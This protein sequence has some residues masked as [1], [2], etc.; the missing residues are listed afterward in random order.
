MLD[1]VVVFLLQ[2]GMTI[3]DLA[4]RKGTWTHEATQNTPATRKKKW[5]VSGTQ[6]EGGRLRVDGKEERRRKEGK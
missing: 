1:D 2:F 3:G 6:P 5:Q 4:E